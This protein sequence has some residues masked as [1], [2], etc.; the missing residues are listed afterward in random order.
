MNDYLAENKKRIEL[1]YV[2]RKEKHEELLRKADILIEKT[3][4]QDICLS[5]KF[6]FAHMPISDVA[7][8][9]LDIFVDFAEH[10]VQLW[11]NMGK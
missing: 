9:D 4:D 10:A 1:E 5:L 6:L 3:T 8:Y 7:N 11:K 2:K